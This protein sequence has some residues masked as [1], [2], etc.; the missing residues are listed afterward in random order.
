MHPL[1]YTFTKLK[2]GGE[3]GLLKIYFQLMAGNVIEFHFKFHVICS[4]A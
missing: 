2:L 3:D 1:A 4:Q